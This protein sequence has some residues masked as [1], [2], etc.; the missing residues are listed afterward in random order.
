M[1]AKSQYDPRLVLGLRWLARLWAAALLLF[2]GAF[3]VEHTTEWFVHPHD[4]PPMEVALL[5]A[6]HFLLLLGLLVGCRW[7]LLG[8]IVAL[9]AAILF[10]PQVSEKNAVVFLMLSVGPA[11]LWIGLGGYAIGR[12]SSTA[13]P[14]VG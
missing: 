5:H 3:F 10:F 8:G 1:T 13:S 4:W 9:A 6:A 14:T 12:R 11:A 7:E 2:W